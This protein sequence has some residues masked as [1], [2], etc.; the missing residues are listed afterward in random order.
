MGWMDIGALGTGKL[1]DVIAVEGDPLTDIR[2]TDKVILVVRE[3]KIVKY[4]LPKSPTL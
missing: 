3:G 1:A 4:Q 2:A